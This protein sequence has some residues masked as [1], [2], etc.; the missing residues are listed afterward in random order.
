MA[1][2]DMQGM[3]TP[4]GGGGGGNVSSLSVIDCP[5]NSATSTLLCL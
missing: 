2:L 3:T 1:I 4:G 5:G